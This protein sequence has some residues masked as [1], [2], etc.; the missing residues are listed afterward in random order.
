MLRVVRKV[1]GVLTTAG[2]LALTGC[3]GGGH[4]ATHTATSP[5]VPSTPSSTSTTPGPTAPVAIAGAVDSVAAGV[6][7]AVLAPAALVAAAEPPGSSAPAVAP[8]VPTREIRNSASGEFAVAHTNGT[9]RRP[10]QIVLKVKASP[11]Q[12]GSVF[13]AVVC[14]ESGGGVSHKQQ[15]ATVQL[16]MTETLPVSVPSKYCNASANV[17]LSKSGSA[18]ISLT[19]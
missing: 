16:P 11:A 14:S 6:G 1:A 5:A 4:A 19:G 7:D 3:G 17:Q 18:T 12:S 9:F 13:W 15:Q 8:P 2:L 10:T